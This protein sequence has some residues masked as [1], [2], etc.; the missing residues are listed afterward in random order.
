MSK[1][2]LS[3]TL[4]LRKFFVSIM[5]FYGHILNLKIIFCDDIFFIF[6]AEKYLG[7]F[8]VGYI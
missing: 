5:K 8:S 3:K 4:L 1:I 7:T 2:D 6:F